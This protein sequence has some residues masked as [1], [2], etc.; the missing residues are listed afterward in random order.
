M[1]LEIF[2]ALKMEE[3]MKFRVRSLVTTK[4]ILFQDQY[5][6]LRSSQLFGGD[7]RSHKH[8]ETVNVSLDL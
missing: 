8:D 4:L 1:K 2:S 5:R 3:A 7:Q 6:K